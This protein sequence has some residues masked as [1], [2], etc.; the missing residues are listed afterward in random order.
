MLA[1]ISFT[2]ECGAKCITCPSWKQPKKH[3]SFDNFTKI[4]DKLNK[5]NTING[6]IFSSTGDIYYHPECERILHY[7]VAN[8][9]KTISLSTNASRMHYIPKINELII[10]FNGFDKESYER[11][12]GLD[13]EVVLNNII[14]SYGEIEHNTE[15]AEIHMLS[16]KDNEILKDD[17]DRLWSDFPGKVRI[18]YKYDNQMKD[19]KTLD[20]YKCDDRFLCDYL[21]MVNVNT[22]GKVISCCH[23][24]KYETNF[25][26]ILTDSEHDIVYNYNRLTKKKEHSDNKFKGLCEK[27][28]Y[29]TILEG[30]IEYVK[31]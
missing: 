12:T 20:D 6:Y 2:T 9:C 26:N 13:Y 27:C 7:A 10:S 31:T 30:K 11:V 4:Y 28:N 16:F 19:D 29:N 21:Y 17:V 3:M 24:F 14:R 1:K 18:S 8:K 25:G 15:N 23:D 22:D 5:W